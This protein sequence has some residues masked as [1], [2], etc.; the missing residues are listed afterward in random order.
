MKITVPC[1]NCGKK[2]TIDTE[3]LPK[4]NSIALK[5]NKTGT[6]EVYVDCPKCGAETAAR[7]RLRRRGNEIL[8]PGNL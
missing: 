3:T 7:C 2:I 1:E 8:E 5:A 4:M 6:R